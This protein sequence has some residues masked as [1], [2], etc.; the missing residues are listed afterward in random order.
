MCKYCNIKTWVD[1][2]GIVRGHC[3]NTVAR[4]EEAKKN[5]NKFFI[6]MIRNQGDNKTVNNNKVERIEAENEEVIS[7]DISYI[8]VVEH[9]VGDTVGHHLAFKIN[10][11]PFCGKKLD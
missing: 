8:K 2:K 9:R 5:G 7:N 4:D 10:Y 6:Q 11:C 3:V 1:K